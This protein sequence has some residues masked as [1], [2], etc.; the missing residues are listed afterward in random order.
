MSLKLGKE[1][2]IDT[3]FKAFLFL[4]NWINQKYCANYFIK[5]RRE[6]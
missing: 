2:Q 6:V 5:Q 3:V 1:L 4:D